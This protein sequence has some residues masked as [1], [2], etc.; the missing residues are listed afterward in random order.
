MPRH[1]PRT[2]AS[3]AALVALLAA[4]ARE[5]T[6]FPLDAETLRRLNSENTAAIHYHEE[7]GALLVTVIDRSGDAHV[8][9]LIAKDL[10]LSQS[11]DLL[12][13]K[14]AELQQRK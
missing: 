5:P 1:R 11:L 3:L 9:R 13:R 12:E 2:A 10:T 8:H 14:Q 6:E 4:C 7:G